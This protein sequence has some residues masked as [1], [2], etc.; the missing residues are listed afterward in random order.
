MARSADDPEGDSFTS[1]LDLSDE[2]IQFL[3][4]LVA[5]VM[6][7]THS[8]QSGND[9][10]T[11]ELVHATG[12][13]QGR[14]DAVLVRRA[15]DPAEWRLGHRSDGTWYISRKASHWAL[16]APPSPDPNTAIHRL[17]I[18]GESRSRVISAASIA[19]DLSRL[20]EFV[21]R[22]IAMQE[23]DSDPVLL[24][25]LF[26]AAIIIYGRVRKG[27]RRQSYWVTNDMVA[28]L[29]PGAAALDAYL[30]GLRDKHVAHSVNAFEITDLGAIVALP[31]RQFVS[32]IITHV[33]LSGWTVTDLKKFETLVRALHDQVESDLSAFQD[34]A[35]ES[36]KKLSVG[37]I[38]R[39]PPL[40][41]TASTEV[42]RPR[43]I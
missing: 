40:T 26:V 30:D 14:M 17:P 27:D 20:H 42:N 31:E 5:R 18:D 24:E 39:Q 11:P 29:G 8:V 36:A 9:N 41:W 23:T 15:L 3:S 38:L 37:E 10:L 1:R 21:S 33:A 32:T 7:L 25:A 13:L 34:A 16:G 19:R 35:E 43:P 2:D 28:K 22:L 6:D 12:R 4:P